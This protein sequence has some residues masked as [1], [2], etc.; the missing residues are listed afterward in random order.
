MSYFLKYTTEQNAVVRSDGPFAEL[1]QL[2]AHTVTQFKSDALTNVDQVVAIEI[3]G[4]ASIE[5]MITVLTMLKWSVSA[6]VKEQIKYKL[7]Y[8]KGGC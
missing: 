8:L 1:R 6:E 4:E 2:I 5:A 7:D 3:N